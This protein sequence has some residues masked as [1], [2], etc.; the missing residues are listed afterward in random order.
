V[1]LVEHLLRLG[2]QAVGLFLVDDLLLSGGHLSGSL[3]VEVEHALL[4]GFSRGHGDVLLL[5]EHASVLYLLVLGLDLGRRLHAFDLVSLDDD[6]LRLLAG[7]GLL[8]DL[9]QLV[10]GQSRGAPRGSGLL[11][12]A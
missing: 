6:R 1:V 3:L 4:A 10:L 12:V 7:L 9:A 5:L 2:Q 8:A 11:R